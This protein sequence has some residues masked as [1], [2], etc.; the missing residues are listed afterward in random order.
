LVPVPASPPLEQAGQ[1]ALEHLMKFSIVTVSF[2]A[3]RT[4]ADTLRSV[5]GQSYPHIEHIVV[6]G[7]SRD[8]TVGL[9]EAH[10]RRGGRYISERDNGLYDAMNKGIA[11]AQGDVIGL[12]NADDMYIDTGILDRIAA[13]VTAKGVDAVLCDVGFF[14]EGAPNKVIRRYNSGHFSPDRLGWG[15]MPAHPGMFLTKKAYQEVGFYRTDY[16]I[17]ADFEFIARAFRVHGLSYSHM[18]EIAVM[19]RTGGIS[20]S[21]FRS[22]M[23]IN[24]EVLRACREN[25]IY[26]NT[27]MLLS[28]YPRKLLEMLA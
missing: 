12:L 16:T 13:H 24:A 2:N 21:G 9:I 15:W 19:M 10:L 18:A 7:G 1:T 28:K 17:A 14:R 25:G 4:I 23:T 26:S 22:K 5:A 3:E 8:G 11:M 27:A 20:T 6:D